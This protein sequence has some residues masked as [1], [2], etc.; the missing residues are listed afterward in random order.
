MNH[1]TQEFFLLFQQSV[2]KL[3][4]RHSKRQSATLEEHLIKKFYLF[5][6]KKKEIIFYRYL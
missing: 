5:F 1:H 2:A 6:I 3:Q 4:N